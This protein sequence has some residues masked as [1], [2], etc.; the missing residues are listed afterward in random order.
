LRRMAKSS[1]SPLPDTNLDGKMQDGT[2]RVKTENICA[3]VIVKNGVIKDCA[4]ILRKK[5][6][7][8]KTIAERIEDGF[9]T[10]T[11]SVS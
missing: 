7:Y 4:P 1:I 2:Y 11:G 10:Q 5:I 8:W 9:D 6:E 3:Y